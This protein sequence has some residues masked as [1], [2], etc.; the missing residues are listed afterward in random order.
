MNENSE[1]D[2]EELKTFP[3]YDLENILLKLI[4]DKDQNG[5]INS[6]PLLI[7]ILNQ[8]TGSN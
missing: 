6:L 5:L 4:R 3:P 2:L 7:F 1:A 8:K